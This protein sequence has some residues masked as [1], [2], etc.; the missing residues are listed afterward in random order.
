MTFYCGQKTN[1][2]TCRR[3]V[4][5]EGPCWQHGPGF[6]GKFLRDMT[7]AEM[8]PSL[9]RRTV[10]SDDGCILWQGSLDAKGYGNVISARL[11][12]GSAH[13]LIY[14]GLVGPIPDGL[15]LDHLCRVPRC[16]NPEHLEPV[17]PRENTLRGVSGSAINATKIECIRGHSLVDEANVYRRKGGRYCRACNREAQRQSTYKRKMRLSGVEF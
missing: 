12:L 17:T 15:V 4:S 6:T 9:L 16:V 8:L 10:R 1:T 3:Q 2:A 11:H 7:P 14:E 5:K 13:R